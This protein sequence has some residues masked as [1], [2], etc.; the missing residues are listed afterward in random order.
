MSNYYKIMSENK[1]GIG[2]GVLSEMVWYVG[3]QDIRLADL[4][5]AAIF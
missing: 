1:P 2:K 5:S 4:S 3:A